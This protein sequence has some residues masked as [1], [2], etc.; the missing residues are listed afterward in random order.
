MRIPYFLT[1]LTWLLCWHAQAFE[2]STGDNV[3]CEVTVNGKTGVWSAYS[4]RT[5]IPQAPD[6][7]HQTPAAPHVCNT[8]TDGMAQ[9]YSF[10]CSPAGEAIGPD[11]KPT[12]VMLASCR[13]PINEAPNGQA[14]DV[15]TTPIITQAATC[16][17]PVG[18]P[19]PQVAS[20]AAAV[21]VP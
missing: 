5:K 11:G 10:S 21:T 6:W 14:V 20:K 19:A 16:N 3:Q 17:L 15:A 1:W 4:I 8:V 7:Q 12:G 2:I 9:C 13:C 18:G